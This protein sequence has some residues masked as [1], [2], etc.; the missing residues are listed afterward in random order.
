MLKWQILLIMIVYC[1]WRLCSI[2]T[3]SW[4]SLTHFSTYWNE[5]R[6]L[7][8]PSTLDGVLT[9]IVQCHHSTYIKT[10]HRKLGS[11]LP[12]ILSLLITDPYGLTTC[13][14]FRQVYFV[15]DFILSVAMTVSSFFS[16]KFSKSILVSSKLLIPQSWFALSTKI[17]DQELQ[18]NSFNISD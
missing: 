4:H 10:E 9:E 17:L 8:F 18:N 2:L 5:H 12:Y 13:L 7:G 15:T 1:D 3:H 16:Y 11:V 6:R 14:I